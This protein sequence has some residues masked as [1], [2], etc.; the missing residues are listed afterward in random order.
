MTYTATSIIPAIQ[1]ERV[2]ELV[3]EG[4][5]LSDLKRY[6]KGVSRSAAQNSNVINLPGSSTT[7][8]LTKTNEDYKFIWPIPTAETDANPKIKQN[9]GYTN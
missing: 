9:P 7:E 2:R 4:F 6:G 1:D 5:R 3:G 8:F